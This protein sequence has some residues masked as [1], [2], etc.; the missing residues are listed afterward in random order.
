M[1]GISMDN[2]Q[3]EQQRKAVVDTN[4]LTSFLTRMYGTMAFAVLISAVSAYVVMNTHR[5]KV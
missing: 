1:G 5:T 4:G 3:P 2:F